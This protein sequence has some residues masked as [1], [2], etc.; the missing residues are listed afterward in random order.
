MHREVCIR[1]KLN[2]DAQTQ[3][4]KVIKNLSRQAEELNQAHLNFQG[5]QNLI[6][7]VF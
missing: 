4:I 3:F 6:F 1:R 2:I 5:H 7:Q